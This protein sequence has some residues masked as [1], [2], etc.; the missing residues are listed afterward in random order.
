MISES[1]GK[2]AWHV[3]HSTLFEKVGGGGI[4]SRQTYIRNEKPKREVARRLRLL[5]VAQNQNLLNSIRVAVGD[6][7]QME[8]GPTAT[9]IRGILKQAVEVLHRA[10]CPKC[11][12]NGSTIFPKRRTK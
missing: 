6:T 1:A 10:E 11:P 7:L 3:H 8:S 2:W 5:K 4:E 12:W 9:K